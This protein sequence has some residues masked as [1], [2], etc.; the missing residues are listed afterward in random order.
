MAFTGFLYSF[1][2]QW[3]SQRTE[4]LPR[5]PGPNQVVFLYFLSII[6][7]CVCALVTSVGRRNEFF[8]TLFIALYIALYVVF[9]VIFIPSALVMRD[10]N[11]ADRLN[12]VTELPFHSDVVKSEQTRRVASKKKKFLL[13]ATVELVGQPMM[14]ILHILIPNQLDSLETRNIETRTAPVQRSTSLLITSLGKE[15]LQIYD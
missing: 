13:T 15:R 1:L 12:K 10:H 2:L 11:R 4:W 5:M 3:W 7:Y 6:I 9:I 8:V 14:R